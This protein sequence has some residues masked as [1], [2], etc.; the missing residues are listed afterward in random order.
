MP[1]AAAGARNCPFILRDLGG[2]KRV[3]REQTN[4]IM[5]KPNMFRVLV[6]TT[7]LAVFALGSS[8]AIGQQTTVAAPQ[9]GAV[10]V[11]TPELA[12]H[13]KVENGKVWVKS[14]AAWVDRG[15]DNMG[16]A[17]KALREIYPNATFA[18]D[19]RVADV[20]VTDVIVRS[21]DP[22][23][24]LEALRTSC[25]GRFSIVHE[26]NFASASG[27][28][29]QNPLYSIVANS[30]TETKPSAGDDRQIECFNLT[31][32]LEREKVLN[33]DETNSNKG[34]GGFP[35]AM[36]GGVAATHVEQ[37]V[38]RLQEI[39]QKSISDFDPSI[40]RPHFQ[41]Y[42]DA[43][44]LIV[45]G[46]ERAIDVAAKVIQALPGQETFTGNNFGGRSVGADLTRENRI[47][48]QQMGA[49]AG[50]ALPLGGNS[51]NPK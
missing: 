15:E 27:A 12:E 40:S 5:K 37:A 13:L 2:D 4:D 43:Q 6:T 30:A 31:R 48:M 44:M 18:I 23:T 38:A 16:W 20:L 7:S 9:G 29:E 25:G 32:Y 26:P 45:I 51:Y 3:V 21:D 42:A 24:D 1:T 8:P 41:F 34:T 22:M 50:T 46:P 28:A 19:P 49:G 39:I 10:A 47:L 11:A 35:G 33:K 36:F 14:G 17:V